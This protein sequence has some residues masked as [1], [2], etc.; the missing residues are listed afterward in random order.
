MT[1][2]DIALFK[3]GVDLFVSVFMTWCLLKFVEGRF[4]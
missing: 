3:I 1:S 2:D 4:K